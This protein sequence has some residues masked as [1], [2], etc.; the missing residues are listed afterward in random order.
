MSAAALN[1]APGAASRLLPWS[2]LASNSWLSAALV[3]LIL[4][5]V[6]AELV[7]QPTDFCARQSPL[8]QPDSR[9]AGRCEHQEFRSAVVRAGNLDFDPLPRQPAEQLGTRPISRSGQ[10]TSGW[11]FVT[12]CSVALWTGIRHVGVSMLCAGRRRPSD[13]IG[14]SRRRGGGT[15]L[16]ARSAANA[17]PRIM[18]VGG[19]DSEPGH[20]FLHLAHR[21]LSIREFD[22]ELRGAEQDDGAE[23]SAVGCLYFN[24]DPDQLPQQMR[25]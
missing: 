14:N 16:I 18:E 1:P 6:H 23:P 19:I 15:K 12:A 2:V 8:R 7:E 20:E 13:E 25:T 10:T 17:S 11:M 21:Q 22:A 5:P 24:P 3:P 9:S 4:S